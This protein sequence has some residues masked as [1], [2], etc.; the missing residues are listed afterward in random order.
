MVRSH[1]KVW[2]REPS[3]PAHRT[4]RRRCL[5]TEDLKPLRGKPDVRAVDVRSPEVYASVH[6]PEAVNIPIDGLLEQARS[7]SR[8][9]RIITVCAKGGGRSAPAAQNLRGLGFGRTWWLCGGTI[10]WR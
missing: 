8:K 9:E 4:A 1:I 6:L 2:L 3:Q 7:W 5:E 10:G